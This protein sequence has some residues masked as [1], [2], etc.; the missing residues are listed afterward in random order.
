MLYV[1]TINYLSL[2]LFIFVSHHLNYSILILVMFFCL[3]FGYFM[4]NADSIYSPLQS[5]E[6]P[7]NVRPSETL[8][9]E[10]QASLS[11]DICISSN[12]DSFQ[13][14]SAKIL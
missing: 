5:V 2:F 10:V 6:S 3:A 12:L 13:I 8:S 9:K 7:N 11:D 1:F 14:Y 4:L